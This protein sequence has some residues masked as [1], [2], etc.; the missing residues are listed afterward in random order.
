MRNTGGTKYRT[1]FYAKLCLQSVH[2]PSQAFNAFFQICG[3]KRAVRQAQKTL[4]AAIAEE[5]PA[6]G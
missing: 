2:N 4:A 6:I 5:S 3:R 1:G